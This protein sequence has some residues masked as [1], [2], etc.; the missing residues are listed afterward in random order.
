MLSPGVYQP[1]CARAMMMT[2]SATQRYARALYLQT[3]LLQLS[4]TE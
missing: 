2:L 4:A 1:W 3:L